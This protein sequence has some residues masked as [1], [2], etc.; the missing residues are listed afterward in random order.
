LADA[1]GDPAHVATV[2]ADADIALAGDLAV[3]GAAVEAADEIALVVFLHL[4]HT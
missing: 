3:D 1:D 2:G 4:F